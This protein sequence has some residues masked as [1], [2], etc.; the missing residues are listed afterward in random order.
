MSR[1]GHIWCN[2]VQVHVYSFQPVKNYS[3]AMIF[4]NFGDIKQVSTQK[5]YKNKVLN[6]LKGHQLVT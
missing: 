3:V 6:I 2:G 4:C 1:E 5:G